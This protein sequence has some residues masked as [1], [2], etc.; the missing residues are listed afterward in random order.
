MEKCFFTGPL[1]ELESRK[2]TKVIEALE[3]SKIDIKKLKIVEPKKK[4][5]P[6]LICLHKI[7]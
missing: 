4:K 6:M 1:Y 2:K 5:E 7:K 3:I